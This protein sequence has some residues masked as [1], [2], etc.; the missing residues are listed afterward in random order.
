MLINKQKWNEIMDG[1]QLSDKE[2]LVAEALKLLLNQNPNAKEIIRGCIVRTDEEAVA[3]DRLE[4]A[5]TINAAFGD[6]VD[7]LDEQD[8]ATSD[9]GLD[10]LESVDIFDFVEGIREESGFVEFLARLYEAVCG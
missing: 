2:Q 9:A 1:L 5:D 6:V 3:I 4:L 10:V 8:D 7:L